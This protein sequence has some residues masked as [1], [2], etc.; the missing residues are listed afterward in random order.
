MLDLARQG[1]IDVFTDPVASPTGFPFKIVQ[2][3]G[4]LSDVK[5]REERRRECDLGYLRHAFERADGSLGWRCS[6]ER[7]AAYVQKGGAEEETT[8]RL[9]LCN[10]LLANVGLGQ[11]RDDGVEE[12]SLVTSGEDVRQLARLLP[13]PT[14]TGYSARRDQVFARPCPCRVIRHILAGSTQPFRLRTEGRSYS[15]SGA[16]GRS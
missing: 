16:V 6:A 1:T 2:L 4:S 12:R 10:A 3:P 11:L 15:S 5:L 14:A 13:S 9:C 8:G 7:V